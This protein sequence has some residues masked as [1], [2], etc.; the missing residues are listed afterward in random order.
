[1][2]TARTTSEGSGLPL[3]SPGWRW[4]GLAGRALVISCGLI[5]SAAAF[6]GAASS[7]TSASPAA[8][9]PVSTPVSAPAAVPASAPV[10]APAPGPT[11]DE[12]AALRASQGAVGRTIGDYTLLDREGRPVQLSRYRGKPLLVSFIYTGCFQVCPATTRVLSRAIAA[13]HDAFGEGR[14]SVISIGFN[15]PADSPQA[16]KSFAA[17]YGI[18]SPDW[19][20]LSPAAAIVPQLTRDFGFGFVATPAGFDHLLQ[21]SVVDA[22]GRIVRQI[23]GDSYSNG[24]LTEPL[25]QLL[26]GATVT[27]ATNLSDIL[28]RVRILCSVYDPITGSY[29]VN[30]GLVVEVAGGATFVAW[31][32]WFFLSEW[33][34][35]RRSARQSRA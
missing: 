24:T 15:Q 25:R 11:I 22:Q 7:T 9:T 10:S 8:S 2:M 1:M 31:I 32:F 29:R 14:F 27:A 23:Y 34:T 35:R 6:G 16:L 20:F 3:A 21:V 30:Y 12:T 13:A 26:T 33:L 28:D 17:Q 4:R 19:E 5:A 18:A